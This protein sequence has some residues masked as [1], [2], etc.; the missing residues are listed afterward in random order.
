MN[1]KQFQNELSFLFTELIAPDLK[2]FK[3][4]NKTGNYQYQAGN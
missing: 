4:V 2:Y 3:E 1:G